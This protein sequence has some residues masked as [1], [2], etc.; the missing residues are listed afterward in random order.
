MP[1]AL[2]DSIA[3]NLLQ[4][5]IDQAPARKRHRNI[6]QTDGRH[7]STVLTV[8]DTGEAIAPSVADSLFRCRSSR[9]P[10]WASVLSRGQT[11]WMKPATVPTL[12]KTGAR[13]GCLYA[14]ATT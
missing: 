14:G 12:P 8:R 3:E 13:R 5:A 11:G 7:A 9:H 2:F 4:N 1:S 6:G 10:D